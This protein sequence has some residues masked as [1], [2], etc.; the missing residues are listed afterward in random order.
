MILRIRTILD[1]ENDVLRDIEIDEDSLLKDLHV[2]IT[3]SY[4]FEGKE[5]ASFF[6]TNETW[7]QG[8]EMS[9]IDLGFGKDYS[10]E[11]LNKLFNSENNRLLYV[12]DFLALW[13]FFIEVVEVSE[14]DK[15]IKYPNL[16][17]SQGE[18]PEDPPIK[19][20]EESN[21]DN[22]ESEENKDHND[23]DYDQF[24]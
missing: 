1:V 12:Y 14:N 13:T 11:S 21:S 18:V 19:I 2:S 10:N 7:D 17:F 4:G 24:Y 16:V 9:L 20:F 8:D 3:K 23:I 5:M 22:E 15:N 6:K